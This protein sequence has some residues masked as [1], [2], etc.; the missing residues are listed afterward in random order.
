MAVKILA[1][2]AAI[3]A[4]TGCLAP[5]ASATEDRPYIYCVASASSPGGKAYFSGVHP[6]TW[7]QYPDDEDAFFRHVSQRVDEAVERSTTYCYALDTFDEA[8]LDRQEGV[9]TLRKGGWEP[10]DLTWRP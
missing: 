5:A 8:G 7:D 1:R 4:A 9:E 3:A 6:G 10:V 2:L